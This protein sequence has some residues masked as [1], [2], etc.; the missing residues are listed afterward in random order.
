MKVYHVNVSS[1]YST[2]VIARQIIRALQARGDQGRL[3]YGWVGEPSADTLRSQGR[4]CLRADAALERLIGAEG[5]CSHASTARLIR[6]IRAFEPDVLHLHNLHGNYLNQRMLFDFL[7]EYRRPV[8]LTLHDCREMTGGCVHYTVNG[9]ANWQRDCAD[10]P[11]PQAYLLRPLY[12]VSGGNF[13]RRKRRYEALEHLYVAA[14]SDWLAEDARRSMLGARDIRRIYN[15]V[16][17]G[18]FR[19][20]DA[21]ALRERLG[22]GGKRVILGVASSWNERKGLHRWYGLARRFGADCRIVLVG[23]ND[24]QRREAPPEIIA[25]PRV[26]APEELAELYSL[27]DVFVNLS[28]EE[29]FGLTTAEAM[30]CGTPA[31]VMNATAGPELVTAETGRVVPPTDD[32]VAEAVGFLCERGKEAYREA[33]VR[34]VRENFSAQRM[35]ADYLELYDV[36]M[37]ECGYGNR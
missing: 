7:R 22:C 28:E 25:L 23:L 1:I 3:G 18:C 11:F 27:A 15:G 21:S 20:T 16:D 5:V 34:R 17:T 4:W 12:G 31:V 10:C 2:G 26:G 35:T 36:M 8:A 6:D 30:A 37:K 9:C 32:A 24:A 14:V 13:A 33:C 29:T 19:P